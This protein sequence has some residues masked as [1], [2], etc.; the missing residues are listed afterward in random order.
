MLPARRR[1]LRAWS[2]VTGIAAERVNVNKSSQVK[3][4]QVNLEPIF[5]LEPISSSA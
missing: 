4:S 1:Q 5:D 3:S 2:H